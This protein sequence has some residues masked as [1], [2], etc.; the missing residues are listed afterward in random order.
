MRADNIA[1]NSPIGTGENLN[2]HSASSHESNRR[3]TTKPYDIVCLAKAEVLPTH[4]SMGPW[5][6]SGSVLRG[7]VRPASDEDR[8]RIQIVGCAAASK[9]H[10]GGPFDANPIIQITSDARVVPEVVKCLPENFKMLILNTKP[11]LPGFTFRRLK[12]NGSGDFTP[13]SIFTSMHYAVHAKPRRK[14]R[15]SQQ[16]RSPA[17]LGSGS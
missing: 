12:C 8:F 17:W 14:F 1:L 6:E 2:V 13:A 15:A 5:F 4:K 9:S 10:G 11:E 16:L 3:V 7:N